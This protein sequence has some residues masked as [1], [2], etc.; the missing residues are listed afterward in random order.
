MTKIRSRRSDRRR[1]QRRG[2]SVSSNTT[3]IVVDDGTQIHG[4]SLVQRAIAHSDQPMERDHP[5]FLSHASKPRKGNQSA[6]DG[7]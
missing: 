6:H 4:D 2:V 1:W 5:V 3:G 7:L